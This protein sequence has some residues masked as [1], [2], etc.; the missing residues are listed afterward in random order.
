MDDPES[1]G[2]HG[3][4]RE[5]GF[6]PTLRDIQQRTGTMPESKLEPAQ[7]IEKVEHAVKAIRDFIMDGNL[8]PGTE[9]PP[10]SEMAKQINVS[11]FSMREALR[12]LQAQGLIDI[13][14]GR[15]TRVAAF[16]TKP[17]AQIMSLT[18]QRLRTSLFDLIEA[19]Q[20]LESRI[21]RLGA[22]RAET[23]H[24]EAMRKTILEMEQNKDDLELCVEKDTE[25]HD[26]LIKASGNKVFE[27]TF[28]PLGELLR[29][30]RKATLGTVGGVERAADGHKLV[31]SAVIDHDPDKAEEY[32]VEHLK[33]SEEDLKKA[34][35]ATQD[36][37]RSS[38]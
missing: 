1:T 6:R 5:N 21:A 9:L 17:A 11:K 28:G 27:I 4:K 16:S 30:S 10:E 29:E 19:R 26:I 15:R 37:P 12:V 31:L 24:I 33:N 13:T 14:Q 34:G 8:K 22:I 3:F 25:F 36:P 18:L 20:L 23:S 38:Y 32:M 35:V 7:R 2:F